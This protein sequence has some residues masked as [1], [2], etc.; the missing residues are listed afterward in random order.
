MYLI[1]LDDATKYWY[2]ENWNKIAAILN[3]R[4]I[5]PIFAIIPNVEDPKLLQY[6]KD[7]VNC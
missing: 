6:E 1:R 2:K 5:K 3:K 4:N 7:N